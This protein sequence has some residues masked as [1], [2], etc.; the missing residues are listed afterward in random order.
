MLSILFKYD[1][2]LENCVNLNVICM[3]V[4]YLVF[5]NN[6][7][8]SYN[9]VLSLDI[10]ECRSPNICGRNAICKNIIGNYRCEC[11][12]GYEQISSAPESHCRGLF[13]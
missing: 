12:H 4:I 7:S 11:R 10:D 9:S 5:G 2:H 6:F 1:S 8:S 13:F 3:G